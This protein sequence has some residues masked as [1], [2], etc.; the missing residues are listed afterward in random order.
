[1]SYRISRRFP[2]A[3]QASMLVP[4][5]ASRSTYMGE[6]VATRPRSNGGSDFTD[7][8]LAES[9]SAQVIGFSSG[10]LAKAARC[11]KEGARHWLNA[12]RCPSVA[13]LFQM[14]QSLPTVRDWIYANVGPDDRAA[15]S[16]SLDTVVQALCAIASHDSEDGR[17]AR[18]M[19]EASMAS[20]SAPE[21]P[22]EN[23]V[24]HDLFE[25]RKRRR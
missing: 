24:I 7:R 13:R 2:Q 9:F 23:F 17:R 1:M 15:Q 14:A 22:R 5:A 3:I 21:E 18:Q 19:I 8:E 4:R 25:E 16:Q 12:S 6:S 11:T 10:Q 20:L